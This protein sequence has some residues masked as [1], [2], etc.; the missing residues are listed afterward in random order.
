[1]LFSLNTPLLAKRTVE[2]RLVAKSP[3]L[4]YVSDKSIEKKLRTW[5]NSKELFQVRR[6]KSLL[7]RTHIL[8]Q[9]PLFCQANCLSFLTKRDKKADRLQLKP[10]R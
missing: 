8:P 7:H 2:G 5:R 1:M 4:I 6:N 9:L 10:V 3:N